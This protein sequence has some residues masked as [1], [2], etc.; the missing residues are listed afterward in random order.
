MKIIYFHTDTIF[1]I[2]DG[3]VKDGI[4]YIDK[5]GRAFYIGDI[6]HLTLV[7]QGII[8]KRYI[9]VYIV[10]G[11]CVVPA[12][13]PV[14][15]IKEKSHH[16]TLTFKYEKMNN[17]ESF[18][19]SMRLAILGNMLKIR[20]EIKMLPAILGFVVAAIIFIIMYYFKLI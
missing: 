11:D 3:R 1:E 16:I 15:E 14:D 5:I 6:E 19:K 7:K 2:Y 12:D 4:L 10:K 8:G 20:K 17:P 18:Y 13:K 9:P